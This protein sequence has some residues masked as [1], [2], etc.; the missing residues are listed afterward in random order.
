M[1]DLRRCSDVLLNSSVQA[2]SIE[3]VKR[4]SEVKAINS[5]MA[6]EM[7]RVLSTDDIRILIKEFAV[8]IQTIYD[9]RSRAERDLE[10]M[11]IIR[12]FPLYIRS[13]SSTA[14]STKI[15]EWRCLLSGLSVHLKDSK[16]NSKDFIEQY[17]IEKRVFQ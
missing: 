9:I 14:F 2:K 13:I 16:E 17:F 3:R 1:R 8:Q 15:C 10:K 6:G 11:S 7:S 4:L 12:Y 5:L